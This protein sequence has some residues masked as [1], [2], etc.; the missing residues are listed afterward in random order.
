MLR[1]IGDNIL[2]LW[3]LLCFPIEWLCRWLVFLSSFFPSVCAVCVL[4][5]LLFIGSATDLFCMRMN[6]QKNDCR[7]L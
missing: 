1:W 5:R 6:G 4:C 3:R 2:L 7:R